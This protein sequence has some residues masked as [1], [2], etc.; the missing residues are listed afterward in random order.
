M[1]TAPT[2]TTGR[3]TV[4]NVAERLPLSGTERRVWHIVG[5]VLFGASIALLVRGLIVRVDSGAGLSRVSSSERCAAAPGCDDA[6]ARVLVPGFVLLMVGGFVLARAQGRSMFSRCRTAADRTVRLTH[7]T[8]TKTVTRY[9]ST[10][11]GPVPEGRTTTTRRESEDPLS[12]AEADHITRLLED[13]RSEVVVEGASS[14]DEARQH[15]AAMLRGR[16]DVAPS[17]DQLSRSSK[18]E[19]PRSSAIALIAAGAAVALVYAQFVL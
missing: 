10:W 6:M 14:D 16:P 8:F 2:G 7:R 11:D 19:L 17:S 18:R 4:P 5:L 13:P 1:P 3:T 15:L 12:P 9:R